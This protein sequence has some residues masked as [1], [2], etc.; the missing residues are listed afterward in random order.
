MSSGYG[1]EVINSCFLERLCYWE[2]H[3]FPLSQE[4]SFKNS[5]LGRKWVCI[6]RWEMFFNFFLDLLTNDW[7][8][9]DGRIFFPGFYFFYKKRTFSRGPIVYFLAF[10]VGI[11][12]KCFKV[13]EAFMRKEACRN[14]NFI[15]GIKAKRGRKFWRMGYW[16]IWRSKR[17]WGVLYGYSFLY[18][19]GDINKWSG[20]W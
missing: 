1:K 19:A 8:Q 13:L 3:S 20:Y 7:Y 11:Q 2:V 6:R 5:S 12:R 14:F 16:R 15:P 18:A 9:A 4:K 10:E 17:W